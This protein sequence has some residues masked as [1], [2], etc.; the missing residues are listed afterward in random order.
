MKTLPKCR[1]PGQ[2]MYLLVIP[3]EAPIPCVTSTHLR[4]G[5]GRK[6]PYMPYTPTSQPPGKNYTPKP[7]RPSQTLEQLCRAL[8]I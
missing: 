8:V 3:G 5:G 7:P 6:G 1:W 4:L 2:L